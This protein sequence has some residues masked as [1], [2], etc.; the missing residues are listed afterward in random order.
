ML[1]PL[2]LAF[3]LALVACGSE[4]DYRECVEK[5]VQEC[6]ATRCLPDCETICHDHH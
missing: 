1:P 5:C 6:A 2:V 3:I 4:Q